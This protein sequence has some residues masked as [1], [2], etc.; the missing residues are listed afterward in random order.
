[1]TNAERFE[2]L[3]T[4]RCHELIVTRNGAN[5]CNY[6][7]ARQWIEEHLEDFTE[8]DPAELERMKATNTIWCVQLYPTG[9]VSFY[10]CEAATLERALDDMIETIAKE[11]PNG[12]PEVS[13][14]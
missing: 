6:R 13:Y 5:A 10:V 11:Y 12:I 2:W 9:S 7:T 3:S 14:E 4:L 8:V 1:M